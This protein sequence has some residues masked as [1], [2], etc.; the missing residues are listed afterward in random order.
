MAEKVLWGLLF[1]ERQSKTIVLYSRVP[2]EGKKLILISLC[3]IFFFVCLIYFRNFNLFADA[4]NVVGARA[5]LSVSVQNPS[6]IF[7]DF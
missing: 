2:L 5:L 3:N 4:T 7:R 6:T 1:C